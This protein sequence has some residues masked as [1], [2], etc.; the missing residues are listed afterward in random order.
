MKVK[1]PVLRIMTA[2]AIGLAAGAMLEFAPLGVSLPILIIEG[3]LLGTA[4]GFVIELV[5]HW[6]S[7][8]HRLAQGG[9]LNLERLPVNVADFITLIVKKM[10]YRRKVRADVA[11]ELAGHFED[12]LKECKTEEER[13]RRA[14][15]LI[16]DFGD[17]KLL[18]VL[19]RRAKKR[20]RPLWR[21]IVARTFQT[22]GA[23]IVCFVLYC[24]Y[25]SLGE[26]TIS[27]NYIEQAA[28]LA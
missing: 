14:K 17:V 27:I 4:I 28:R 10:R 1:M 8:R 11:A 15:K 19:L 3:L 16:A 5:I 21:T 9:R 20:C 2:A 25:I 23:L 7:A 24:V 22:I 26:P 6:R 12:A 13:D 18:A